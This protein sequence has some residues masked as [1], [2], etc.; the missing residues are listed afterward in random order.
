MI[1]SNAD[2]ALANT[3]VIPSCRYVHTAVLQGAVYDLVTPCGTSTGYVLKIL[4]TRIFA[5]CTGIMQNF[6]RVSGKP[7]CSRL[8][9]S[10]LLPHLPACSTLPVPALRL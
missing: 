4:N 7:L 10:P 9:P 1:A 2:I 5:M 3:G 6:E 8:T